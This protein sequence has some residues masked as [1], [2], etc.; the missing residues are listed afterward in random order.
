MLQVQIQCACNRM[1][2]TAVLMKP[3]GSNNIEAVRMA[4]H[5]IAAP[6][7][8]ALLQDIVSLLIS[9]TFYHVTL[10]SLST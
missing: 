7:D 1:D 6:C 8:T 10:H 9:C 4:K 5:I 3:V 2:A